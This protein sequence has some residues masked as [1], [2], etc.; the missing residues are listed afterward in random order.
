M[1]EFANCSSTP[2]NHHDAE[3]HQTTS[4][5]SLELAVDAS[6]LHRLNATTT[7]QSAAQSRGGIDLSVT[8]HLHAS[9]TTSSSSR[10]QH[11][12]CADSDNT[13]L[14]Q[15]LEYVNGLHANGGPFN[16]ANN[17]YSMFL[18]ITEYIQ[19]LQILYKRLSG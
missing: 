3:D 16:G 10:H 9:S 13:T 18:L 12:V 6:L 5:L 7:A 8:A 14:Q 11:P 2:A 19:K 4:A 15:H 17:H 1:Y